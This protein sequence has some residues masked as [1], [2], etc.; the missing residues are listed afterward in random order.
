MIAFSFSESV[1][2]LR[3][4]DTGRLGIGIAGSCSDEAESS[5]WE[6]LFLDR[7]KV[8]DPN[9]DFIAEA[10]ADIAFVGTYFFAVTSSSFCSASSTGDEIAA[11]SGGISSFGVNSLSFWSLAISCSIGAVSSAFS[12]DWDEL[13]C[14]G[15]YLSKEYIIGSSLRFWPPFG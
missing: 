15:G 14:S 8:L 11:F 13:V 5:V 1:E 12:N 7:D 2:E 9:P 3:T 6:I 10:N 4:I